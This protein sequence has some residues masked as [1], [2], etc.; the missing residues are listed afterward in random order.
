[1]SVDRDDVFRIAGLARLHL[2]EAEAEALGRDLNAILAYVDTL[3]SVSVDE[4]TTEPPLRAVPGRA[5]RGRPDPLV[6]SLDHYAPDFREGFFVVPSPPSLG[7][8]DEPPS[9]HE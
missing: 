8:D 3:A 7:T 5:P 1:M 4:T 9:G 6:G 2:S